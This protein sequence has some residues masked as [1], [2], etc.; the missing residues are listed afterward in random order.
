[1]HGDIS[2]IDIFLFALERII[3]DSLEGFGSL[4]LWSPDHRFSD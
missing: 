3:R 2:A 4:D 1:M